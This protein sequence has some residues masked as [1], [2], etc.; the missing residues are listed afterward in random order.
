MVSMASVVSVRRGITLTLAAA[1]AGNT[2]SD[3]PYGAGV[4]A[5][6]SQNVAMAMWGGGESGSSR[7]GPS[8]S[9]S[10][11]I[12]IAVLHREYDLSRHV[13]HL[14]LVAIVPLWSIAGLAAVSNDYVATWGDSLLGIAIAAL[15]LAIINGA[16]EGRHFRSAGVVAVARSPNSRPCALRCVP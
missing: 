10:S 5:T 14:R 8:P 6:F 4:Y 9:R 13:T 11:S 16:P 1:A 7:R 15:L 3:D 2:W 12:R